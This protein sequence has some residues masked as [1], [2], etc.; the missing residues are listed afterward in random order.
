M[1]VPGTIR[2]ILDINIVAGLQAPRAQA[3]IIQLQVCTR[4]V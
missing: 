3:R 1:Y 4:C 2:E